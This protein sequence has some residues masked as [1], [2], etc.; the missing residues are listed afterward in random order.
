MASDE[1]PGNASTSRTGTGMRRRPETFLG[2]LR[3]FGRLWGFLAFAVLVVVLFRGIVLPFVFA[4]LMAYLLAPVVARM[5]PRIGRVMGVVV[6]YLGILGFVAAFF[7]LLVPA[8]FQDVA[9]FREGL[10]EA[11]AKLNEEWLPQASEWVDE[12]FS[13]VTSAPD[14]PPPPTK[15]ELIVTPQ[16]DGSW[17]MD[18]EGVRMHAAQQPDGSWVLGPPA[19]ESTERNLG[20]DLRALLARRS[21]EWTATIGPFLRSLV[22]GVTDFLTSLVITFMIAAF[23]LIDVAR[24]NRF[25][26]S[27]VP[28]EYR[29]DFEEL[30]ASMDKGLS[31]VIRGQLLICLVNG[32][33]TFLG[34]VIFGIKYSF[35]LAVL[36]GVFSLIP[37][38]GTIISSIPIVV[39]ALVSSGEQLSYGPSIGILAWIAGI[40]LLEA[41]VLNPKIIGDSAHIHPVLVIFAL[42]AGEHMFGLVGALLAIPVTSLV[43]AAFL[44][45][46]RHSSVFAR[47][48][49]QEP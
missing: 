47:D 4:M 15:T 29:L 3:R 46:R 41:N 44:H 11:A 16:A 42:L 37:I 23:V 8:L 33:L 25:V 24:V 32:A 1:K 40:H 27:L 21:S 31:G 7:V 49:P 18:L 10:P 36:A 19:T 12:T 30:W 34:L 20:D 48:T 22:A 2:V 6:L 13:G 5:Q 14:P 39:I 45:A 26:R 28:Y 9:R 43:Q 17:K 38:F 35:L